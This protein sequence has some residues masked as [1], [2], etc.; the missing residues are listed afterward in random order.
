[1]L[2]AIPISLFWTTKGF[3]TL[4]SNILGGSGNLDV[5]GNRFIFLR[6]D[7]MFFLQNLVDYIEI[8]GV[9]IFCVLNGILISFK[10]RT[11][12]DF[13]LLS[14]IVPLFV[15]T[16]CFGFPF[17][18]FYRG[19]VLAMCLVGGY[20]FR[21][22]PKTFLFI[23]SKS[24]RLKPIRVDERI[25][26]KWIFAFILVVSLYHSMVA[27]HIESKEMYLDEAHA[28]TKPTDATIRAAIWLSN[29]DT[30]WC[31]II[32]VPFEN[33]WVAVYAHKIPMDALISDVETLRGINQQKTDRDTILNNLSTDTSHDLLLKY[34]I[35]YFLISDYYEGTYEQ[36]DKTT[37]L[38]LIYEK[39]SVRIYA[40]INQ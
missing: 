23:Q 4:I 34:N 28:L 15:L 26:A 6:F 14:W 33:P 3:I 27:F 5:A 30:S 32:V 13:F 12:K 37:F 25:L 8:L 31:R 2:I 1:M 18:H 35:G 10:Q 22:L 24:E 39:D 19:L 20:G 11:S 7:F 38:N 40:V 9:L 21:N 29:Y 17:F 36:Y 16:S